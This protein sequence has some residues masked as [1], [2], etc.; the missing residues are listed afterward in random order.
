MS[1][2]AR[3]RVGLNSMIEVATAFL[4]LFSVGI[5]LAHALDAYNAK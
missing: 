3:V 4:G 2:R 5:F 1:V